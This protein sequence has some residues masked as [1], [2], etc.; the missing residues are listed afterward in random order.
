MGRPHPF[1]HPCFPSHPFFI[2]GV[3]II[4]ADE[5][6]CDLTHRQLYAWLVG[7]RAGATCPEIIESVKDGRMKRM[8]GCPLL[9][10]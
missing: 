6:A 1:I 9:S 2:Q 3:L 4:T 5:E 7:V 10:L 8:D